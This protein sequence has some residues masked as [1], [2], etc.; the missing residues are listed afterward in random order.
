M[1]EIIQ[2]PVL[3]DNYIYVLH[4]ADSKETAVIDPAV[5]EPVID[6]LESKGWRLRTIINTHH[7]PDHVGGNLKLKHLTG[8]KVIAAKADRER[9]PGIDIEVADGDR[10]H[11][12]TEVLEIIATPGHTSG[13]FVVYCPDSQALF[14][15]DTL[16]SLGCGRLFEGSAAQMYQS[17]QKLKALPVATRMYCAHEYTQSNGR[18]AMTLEADN[19]ELQARMQDVTVLRSQNLATLPTTLGLELATNPFLRENSPS[20]R[21]TLG[22]N[23]EEAPVNV[24]RKIRQLKDEFR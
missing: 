20:I 23:A 14:C 15:G 11:L 22:F 1:L 16:F 6:I 19:I 17:L 13:H 4:D 24:F 21:Q 18:F 7:H 2:I 8:C 12:G 10:L 3:N 9:I 5:A